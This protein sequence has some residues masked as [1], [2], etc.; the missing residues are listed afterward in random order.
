[1]R[2]RAM[3]LITSVLSVG[4]GLVNGNIL[5][6]HVVVLEGLHGGGPAS[7][8]IVAA[9]GL[10]VETDGER[11]LGALRAEHCARTGRALASV[12]EAPQQVGAVDLG[13]AVNLKY[14]LCSIA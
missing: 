5:D 4:A 10:G 3:L 14:G 1:M 7:A 11:A 2:S 9:G 6:L 12:G 8:G 13:A